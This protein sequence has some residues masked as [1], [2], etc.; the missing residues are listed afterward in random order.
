[1]HPIVEKNVYKIIDELYNYKGKK[2]LKVDIQTDFCELQWM[3]LVLDNIL[4]NIFQYLLRNFF[5]FASDVG[6]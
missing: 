6:F 1:M 3:F 2:N 5:N 4:S